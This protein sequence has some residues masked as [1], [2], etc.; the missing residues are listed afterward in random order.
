MRFGDAY[1]MSRHERGQ[2]NTTASNIHCHTPPPKFIRP[3][4]RKKCYLVGV[5]IDEFFAAANANLW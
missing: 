3:S 4:G 2:N 5:K 1:Q